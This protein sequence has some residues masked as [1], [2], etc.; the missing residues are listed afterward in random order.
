MKKAKTIW[1]TLIVLI[2]IGGGV[3]LLAREAKKPGVYDTLA[4]C[5]TDSG[6]KFYGAWW[7]PHC[8]AQK[9]M[10]GKS[11]KKLPYIECQTQSRQLTDECIAA[12]IEG[13][14]TWIF[15]DGTRQTGEHTIEA[16]AEKTNCELPQ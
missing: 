13:Y 12:D 9:A 4:Q 7:C 8:Q 14:P 2:V 15:A 11:G 6:A 3:Y 5:I 10:F 1:I 16:L